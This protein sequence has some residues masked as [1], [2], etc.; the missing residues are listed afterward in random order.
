[1]NLPQF[2]S[3]ASCTSCELHQEA[4]HPGVPTAHYGQSVFP[5]PDTPFLIVIGMNPGYHEDRTN[6]CFVGTAG[7]MLKNGY[8]ESLGILDTHAVYF[9]NAVRCTTP[10][11][12]NLKN[13]HIKKCWP[14]T[15]AD[16]KEISNWHD[17]GGN[18][19]CLGTH[20]AQAATKHLIGKALSLSKALDK[21]GFALPPI[22]DNK[23]LQF[24]TTYHPAAVLR[25]PR[26]KY[27][28]AEHLDLI[29]Q[30][31][32]GAVASPSLPTIVPPRSPR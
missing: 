10:G 14:H 24:F 9:T 29:G 27:A 32:Q 7:K 15:K 30:H 6:E 21:Q 13:S 16:I 18:I 25:S 17:V 26:L 23:S 28:V 2:P 8:M 22:S 20:A 1:M 31:L 12:T 5:S 11:E 4:N 19:L 3:H